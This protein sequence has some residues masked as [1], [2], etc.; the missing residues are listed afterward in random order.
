[1]RFIKRSVSLVCI[2]FLTSTLHAKA[3]QNL[4]FEYNQ[5]RNIRVAGLGVGG[6][7]GVHYERSWISYGSFK[8]NSKLGISAYKLR[9]FE[10]VLNPD[11]QI[12]MSVGITYG[13]KHQAGFK[14]GVTAHRMVVIKNEVKVSKWEWSP[15][16]SLHYRFS[17]HPNWFGQV[18]MN[19]IM[20]PSQKS[21]LWPGISIGRIL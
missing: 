3:E 14:V 7:W 4:S 1:M 15:F 8:L 17:F 20:V 16:L 10:N 18:A 5:S 2:V 6:W 21:Y 9:D 13:D 11:I 19:Y 12:P